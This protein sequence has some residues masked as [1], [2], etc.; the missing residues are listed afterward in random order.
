MRFLGHT[1]LVLHHAVGHGSKFSG[2]LKRGLPRRS[3]KVHDMI[4]R[5]TI[6]GY[7]PAE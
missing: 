1:L 6:R 2:L 5:G 4:C 3:H 7:T